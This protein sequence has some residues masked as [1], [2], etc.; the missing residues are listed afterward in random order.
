MRHQVSPSETEGETRTTLSARDFTQSASRA[1]EANDSMTRV[2]VSSLSQH[3]AQQV[4]A[5]VERHVVQ[6]SA[7]ILRALI[8]PQNIFLWAD[9]H[10]TGRFL[11]VQLQ[12]LEQLHTSPRLQI[13]VA[14]GHVETVEVGT[15]SHHSP[16]HVRMELSMFGRHEWPRSTVQNFVA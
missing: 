3:V 4:A 13:R 1:R 7:H 11:P 9:V 10:G 16:R 5:Q 2:E 12:R 14:V 8:G 15:V 6:L